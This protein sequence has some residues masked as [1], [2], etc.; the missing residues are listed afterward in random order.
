MLKD[1]GEFQ[2]EGKT[3]KRVNGTGCD[4]CAFEGRSRCSPIVDS[5]RHQGVQGCYQGKYHEVKIMKKEST[6][7]KIEMKS[8]DASE[9]LTL[10]PGK[11]YYVREK[12]T[13]NVYAATADRDGTDQGVIYF[14]G[15]GVETGEY[16]Y[17]Q[18]NFSIIAQFQPGE[19]VVLKAE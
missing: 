10:E 8:I 7:M 3:Y 14:S 15:A 9:E 4:G 16:D 2:Y 17:F 5:A 1:D 18:E 11:L 19:Q 12:G 13:G 6:G